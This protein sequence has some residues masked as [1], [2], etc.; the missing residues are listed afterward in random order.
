MI[1]D[2]LVAI[3]MT[4]LLM[5]PLSMV[6]KTT[7]DLN[8]S[9]IRVNKTM[10]IIDSE[11]AEIAKGNFNE[12][13]KTIGDYQIKSSLSGDVIKLEIKDNESKTTTEY[14]TFKA[15]IE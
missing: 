13:E 12:G 11:N 14:Y 3:I 1:I 2:V 5:M 7:I 4:L 8:K 10:D 15:G 9:A 6:N